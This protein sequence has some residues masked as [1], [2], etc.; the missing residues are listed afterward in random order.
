LN[1]FLSFCIFD[2]LALALKNTS[3]PE[4]FQCIEI[5]FIIQYFLATCA[6]SENKVCPEIIHC[7]EIFFIIQDFRATCACPA[8]RPCPEIFQDT[9]G[10]RPPRP[11]PRTP[12]ITGVLTITAFVAAFDAKAF[13]CTELLKSYL[14]VRNRIL[15]ATG[16]PTETATIEIFDKTH[17][18]RFL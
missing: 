4:V 9:G 16:K 6:C 12:M 14:A 7:I 10:D 11:P 17:G 8:H 5:F 1:C 15:T 13:N 2:Q 3:C 18:L